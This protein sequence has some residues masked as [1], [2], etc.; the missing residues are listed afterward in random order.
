MTRSHHRPRGKRLQK[1]ARPHSRPGVRLAALLL[2]LTVL[3]GALPTLASAEGEETGRTMLSSIVHFDS[4]TLHYA[5]A[6]GRPGEQ[7][8]E[9]ALLDPGAHLA[10]HYRYS[11]PADKISDVQ[12]GVLYYLN[13]SSHLKLTD[14]KNGSALKFEGTDEEFGTIYADSDNNSA[15]VTFKPG[16]DGTGTVLSDNEALNNAYFY[17]DCTRAAG[18]GDD[19]PV[20][21]HSNLYAMKFENTDKTLHFGY[22][23][24]EPV[25]AKAKI[26]KGGGL[27]GRTITWTIDYTPWQNPSAADP[28]TADTPFELRDTI[29]TSLHSYVGGSTAIGGQP[30]AA[31]TSRAGIPADAETYV[32]VDSTS[33][34]GKTLLTFGGTKFNA[35]QATQ[36]NPAR[37][38]AITYQTTINDE[39]LLPGGTGGKNVTNQAELFAGKDGAFNGLNISSSTSVPIPQ[40]TWL[41]KTGETKRHTDGTGSTTDWTVTFQPNGFDFA[42][43]NSLTLH[44]Q[45][46]KGSTL[47]QTSVTVKVG[48]AAEVTVTPDV[49]A[50]T[51]EKGQSFTVPG[52]ETANQPVIIEYQTSVPEEMYD[53]GTGLGKNTAWFTLHYG[54]KD[55]TTSPVE[56]DVGSG[57]GSHTPGTATLVK[58]NT[59]YKAATRTI[60]WTLIIN[61]HKADL[62]SG[63]FTDDLGAVG[64][65]TCIGDGHKHGLEL[66]KTK[67]IT[68]LVDGAAV[69]DDSVTAVYSEQDQTITVETT[70]VGR[71]TV[72][73]TYTTKVCDP[74]VFANNTAG[75]EFKN[76]V[77]TEN[78]II[79]TSTQPRKA[80]A[81][82][83]ANAGATVLTKKAPVYDYEHG[84]MKWT[85]EVDAA[86][87]PMAGV[88]LTDELPAGLTYVADTLKTDPEITGAK[89]AVSGQTLTID[90]GEVTGKT[91]VT[92]DTQVDPEILGFGGA[93]PVKVENTIRMNGSADEVTFAEVSHRVEQSFSNHGLV[94]SSAVNNADELIRYEVLINPF[95]LALPENPSLVDTLDKRLQLDADTLMFYEAAVKGTSGAD[96][97][98]KPSYQTV[99]DGQKLKAADLD[100]EHNSFT[101][102]L[103]IAAGGTRKA[104]VLTYTAD[105]IDRETAGYSNSVRFDGGSVMLGG[106]K[107][108]SAQV[109][110]G[111]GG[112]GGGGVA[113][114]KATL[115]II[116]TDSETG[117]PIP[118]VSFTL[119]QWDEE[120]DMRGLP[121]AQGTTDAQGKLSFRVTPKAAYELVETASAPGYGSGF[122]EPLP[123][124]VTQTEGGGLRVTAGAARSELTLDLT[125]VAHTT[126]IVFRLVNA[127]GIPMAGTDVEL[128]REDPDEDP[129]A[130]PVTVQVDVDGT[131]KFSGIRRGAAYFIRRPGGGIMTVDVPAEENEPPTVTVDGTTVTLTEDYRAEGVTKPDQ[132]WKLTVRKVIT[133]GDTPLAGAEIGLYADAEC[134]G[135]IGSG[136]SGPDGTV[137]FSGLIKGQR[138]WVKETRAPAGYR[139]DNTVHEAAED[140]PVRL[141]NTPL[142]DDPGGSGK[143]DKPVKPVEPEVPE[144]PDT[145]VEPEVS[146]QPDTPVETETPAQPGTLPGISGGPDLSQQPGTSLWPGDTLWPDLTNGMDGL[147]WGSSFDGPDLI[148]DEELVGG[149]SETA[150]DP[151]GGSGGPSLV[152][153]VPQTG[154]NTGLPAVAALLS[155]VLLAAMAV[156]RILAGKPKRRS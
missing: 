101:V 96:G 55:H 88:I 27:T 64:P 95:H 103:P 54:T 107:G 10:L 24:N 128:F 98:G 140:V 49:T 46:P 39:L 99:G 111:G 86:G 153:D 82:S 31:Y 30:V 34:S 113:A 71:R 155:G 9:N 51:E 131:V 120:N 70:G 75:V 15:W 73:L 28:V 81:D 22:A 62:K 110:G 85:V 16:E 63:T 38:F 11:I 144:Q 53:S 145:T 148:V 4:I 147:G 60:D 57:D 74:C 137:T 25:N 117:A 40:L 156:R 79:G 126:D 37:S 123:G 56:T 59:G 29:D 67:G 152:S 6:D 109:S 78:M 122:G 125:N 116:K 87:L 119:Y 5:D 65:Q 68:V 114:R 47:D 138:Y 17:L 112:G 19:P 23:E 105:I 83:T 8:Q 92:F 102:Q 13:V 89:A 44:D 20:E 21:G 58:S 108:N 154:D 35:G 124:G 69:T 7:V 2:C 104:Y 48:E 127:S 36:G 80:S 134:K 121:F 42:G 76:T 136:V 118:G 14:L 77:S 45:L 84:V 142:P 146:E 33:E 115:S 1:T 139:L 143:P 18:P 43:D 97:N 94:K 41:T 12:A 61:P 3:A 100:L 149:A 26:Q 66:D 132:E 91:T 130:I 72:T 90:L 151:Y 141:A 93:Q 135:Q 150:P 50:A 32:L 129:N 133:G 106:E 52:I